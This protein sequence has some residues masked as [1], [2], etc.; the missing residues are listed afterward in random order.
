MPYIVLGFDDPSTTDPG[1]D[2]GNGALFGIDAES[3]FTDLEFSAG[4]PDGGLYTLDKFGGVFVLGEA[5]A[6]DN[7]PSPDFG[8]SPY[9]FPFLYAEDLEVF[10]PEETTL[11]LN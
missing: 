8:N 9:F 7:D 1:A 2:E 6:D 11:N 5:R 4:C 10:G 3:I